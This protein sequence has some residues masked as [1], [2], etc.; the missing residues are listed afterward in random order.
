MSTVGNYRTI[1]DL[2]FTIRQSTVFLNQNFLPLPAMG[3]NT[4]PE[5]NIILRNFRKGA[6]GWNTRKTTSLE[7]EGNFN[8]SWNTCA[9]GNTF[10]PPFF[11]GTMNVNSGGSSTTS[12]GWTFIDPNFR[13]NQCYN[14]PISIQF[15]WNSNFD[16][17]I[18]G[19]GNNV[20]NFNG[21]YN[22]QP[23]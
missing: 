2:T 14:D 17:Q 10:M 20:S 18:T 11:S 4:W 6:F 3:T 23:N 12:I 13:F 15:R 9:F 19:E 8:H 5:W 16:I 21:T 7:I 22:Y 1:T